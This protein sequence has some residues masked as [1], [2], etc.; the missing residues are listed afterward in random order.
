MLYLVPAMMRMRRLDLAKTHPHLLRP[1]ELHVHMIPD[2]IV[3][4]DR[5]VLGCA[6]IRWLEAHNDIETVHKFFVYFAGLITAASNTYHTIPEMGDIRS[7]W[8]HDKLH[9]C[10]VRI[11]N[12]ML[13]ISE[14]PSPSSELFVVSGNPQEWLRPCCY[15]IR[16]QA[17]L[18]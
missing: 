18:S 9:A 15:D 4:T 12:M 10:V 2:N 5:M 17:K 13:T 16:P 1:L 3:L 8:T 14:K 11:E 6:H 7:T